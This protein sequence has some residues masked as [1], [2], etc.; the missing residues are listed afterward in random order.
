M[1]SSLVE[2][3]FKT[4]ILYKICS[5]VWLNFNQC[6]DLN[7]QQVTWFI[8]WLILKSYR[9]EPPISFCRIVCGKIIINFYGILIFKFKRINC[10]FG[11][12]LRLSDNFSTFGL[13]FLISNSENYKIR[14]HKRIDPIK[15][16]WTSWSALNPALPIPT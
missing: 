15:D 16:I 7:L 1:L 10:C 14:F 9:R 12:F 3:L 5:P 4:K 13:F 2:N 11:H 6:E 8:T